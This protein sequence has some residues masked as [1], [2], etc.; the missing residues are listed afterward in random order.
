MG[1][2]TYFRGSADSRDPAFRASE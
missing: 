1:E 2:G